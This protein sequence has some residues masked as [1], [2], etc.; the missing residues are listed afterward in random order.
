MSNQIFAKHNNLRKRLVLIVLLAAAFSLIIFL[1]LITVYSSDDYW[2]S[3]FMDHG[4]AAYFRMMKEHYLTFNG[5]M[6]VHF[7][8]HAILHCGNWLFA[9][10]LAGCCALIPA[11]MY[12]MEGRGGGVDGFLLCTLLFLTGILML[13]RGIIVD[14]FLW[15]SASCNYV[16]PTAM[17]VGQVPLLRRFT[18]REERRFY[19]AD[20]LLLGYCFLCG[21]TTEQMGAVAVGVAGLFVLK[22]LALRRKRVWVSL[23][24]AVCACCGVL[25][26]FLSPATRQRMMNETVE[27]MTVRS[28]FIQHMK[29]QLGAQTATFSHSPLI[30]AVFGTLFF[31]TAWLLFRR[32]GTP[33]R[34]AGVWLALS[35][36]SLF[37][38]CVG[39]GKLL[40]LAY[41]AV[42][43]LTAL[44]TVIWLVCGYEGM[45]FVLLAGLGSAGIILFTNSGVGRTFLPF[46]LCLLA[47]LAP[48]V[49]ILLEEIPQAMARGGVVLALSLLS[50]A[51]IG[52]QLPGYWYNY[53]IDRINQEAVSLAKE[54]GELYYCMDYDKSYTNFK[55]YDDGYFHDKWIE[56]TGLDPSVCR[57]YFYGEGLPNIY[58]AGERTESPAR[59]GSD[60]T[61]LLPLRYTIENLGGSLELGDN[62][63]DLILIRL[64]GREYTYTAQGTEVTV[65][66]QEGDTVHSVEGERSQG[67]YATFISEGILTEAFGLRVTHRDEGIYVDVP[68]IFLF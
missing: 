58:V 47:V 56:S 4:A 3:T 41:L 37:L 5:R 60:G 19:P 22:N 65:Q 12:A 18:G 16:L 49:M 27:D 9:L 17:V 25:T 61:W 43:G 45:A 46:C 2:Y 7:V 67:Y 50:F 55:P 64:G 21:A 42:I 40:V 33:K 1:A 24:A 29:Y 6:L 30:I 31:F 15:I 44:Q 13:P 66:W 32:K 28:S 8:A 52:V 35:A 36:V 34:F 68:S 51:V 54:T 39:D 26:I 48:A 59:P 57:I 63:G 53:R 20:L 23:F 10:F 11:A 62:A 14:G 38:L